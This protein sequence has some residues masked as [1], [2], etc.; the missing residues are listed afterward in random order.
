MLVPSPDLVAGA[1]GRLAHYAGAEVF[2]GMLELDLLGD[3]HA[4]IADQRAPKLL[5]EQHTFGLGS[6]RDA[7]SVPDR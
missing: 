6:E 7:H 5:V 2:D 1:L 3:S 4:V